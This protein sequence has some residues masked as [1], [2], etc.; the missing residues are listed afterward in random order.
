M[1]GLFA[2]RF[3]SL[4]HWLNAPERR[5]R[6]ALPGVLEA[7]ESP[8]RLSRT[9]ETGG[10]RGW[11]DGGLALAGRHLQVCTAWLDGDSQLGQEPL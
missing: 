7:W 11:E 8:E 3:C 5:P 1:T 4:L 6:Q 10:K 9:R 2:K